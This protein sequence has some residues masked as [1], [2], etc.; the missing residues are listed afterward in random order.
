MIYKLLTYPNPFLRKSTNSLENVYH[1]ERERYETILEELRENL[2]YYQD[3]VAITAN[4]IGMSYNAFVLNKEN[5]ELKTI[6]NKFGDIFLDATYENI[7]EE[8]E[9]QIEGCLSFPGVRIPVQ[10]YKKIKVMS[11][12]KTFA[13]IELELSGFSA[14]VFM[15]EIQHTKGILF[16]DDLP[17]SK[18][19]KIGK[20]LA[21]ASTK[22]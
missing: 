22:H 5:N 11:R 15:H 6:V 7:G 18:R 14:R 20:Q 12:D 4:Q 13:K 10:R 17:L 3:G 2:R 8:K 19:L 1:N 9:T 16:I 21:N